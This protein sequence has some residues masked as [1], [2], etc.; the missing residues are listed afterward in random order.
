MLS[1]SRTHFAIPYP[2]FVDS[3]MQVFDA[4]NLPVYL[5]PFGC[6]FAPLDTFLFELV[7]RTLWPLLV[8]VLLVATSR[9]TRA[10]F[11]RRTVV[12]DLCDDLWLYA[13]CVP[14]TREKK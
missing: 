13:R 14:P 7:T 9:C 11:G 4:V 10:W 3:I 8:V 2:S 1:S 6:A 12:G 5:I